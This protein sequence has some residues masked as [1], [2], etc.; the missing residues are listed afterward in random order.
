MSEQTKKQPASVPPDLARRAL[1]LLNETQRALGRNLE[2]HRNPSD[3]DTVNELLGLHDNDNALRLRHELYQASKAAPQPEAQPSIQDLAAG[4]H[5]PQLTGWSNPA[6][7]AAANAGTA[8]SSAVIGAAQPTS[9]PEADKKLTYRDS[10]G[11]MREVKGCTVTVDKAGRHWIWSEQLQHNLVYRIK[12]REDALIA[13]IDSLLFTIQL[14]D[15][16]IA[17]LQRIVNLAE[18]FAAEAFPQESDS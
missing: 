2:N 11:V 8:A 12:E 10:D 3:K 6:P 1:D 18:R 7:N 5:Y 15:Q 13:S 16:R 17:E 9:V 14:R 4:A